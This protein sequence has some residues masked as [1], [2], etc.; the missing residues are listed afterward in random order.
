MARD[1][2]HD[3]VRKA[4]EQEG[5]KITHDPFP[6]NIGNIGY[7]VDLGAERLI[8]AEK[9]HEKIAVEVKSFT[10]PSDINEFHR[11]MGQFNDY[12]VVLEEVEPERLLFLAI[13]EEIWI[14]FFQERAIQRAVERI[15][16]KIIVYSPIEMAIKL[17]IK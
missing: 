14:G 13:P 6:L 5:W 3:V 10:G 11:A 8:A 4:L 12:Y 17:W 16:A 7:E 2:Y 9:N 1:F 15:G